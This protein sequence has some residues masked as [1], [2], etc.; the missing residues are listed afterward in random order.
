MRVN[1]LAFVW[2][3]FVYLTSVDVLAH[4]SH[5]TLGR[6]TALSGASESFDLSHRNDG[7]KVSLIANGQSPYAA[8]AHVHLL[9]RNS[10][11]DRT[12]A[13][14]EDPRTELFV[15]LAAGACAIA[16]LVQDVQKVGAH[17][18][19]V[20]V[21]FLHALKSLSSVMKESKTVIKGISKTYHARFHN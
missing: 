4:Q 18:A 13:F 16:E 6:V 8:H 5:S 1:L 9:D 10:F 17:H 7:S 21:T 19:I 3:S 15:G 14:L 12:I 20:L 11:F 2:I